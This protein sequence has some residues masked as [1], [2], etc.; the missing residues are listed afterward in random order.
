MPKTN[1][2]FTAKLCGEFK[3]VIP[4]RSSGFSKS[5]YKKKFE[6]TGPGRPCPVRPTFALLGKGI[7]FM[8]F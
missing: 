6:R 2:F 3:G 5:R 1:V 7:V 8:T 4:A